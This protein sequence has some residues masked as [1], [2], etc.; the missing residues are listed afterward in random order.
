VDVV[1]SFSTTAG[2]PVSVSYTFTTEDI[3]SLNPAWATGLDSGVDRGFNVRVVQALDSS[4]RANSTVAAEGQLADPAVPA[5][6]TDVT[7]I[8]QMINFN[9][10]IDDGSGGNGLFRGGSPTA[11]YQ[12][13]DIDM[14]AEGLISSNTDD[15]DENHT[16]DWAMEVKT[17]VAYTEAGI[18]T[19]VVNSDDGFRV[20][21]GRTT[22]IEESTLELGVFDGGRGASND[23]AQSVFRY[24]VTQPGLYALRFI[25][26]EGGGGSSMEWSVD[27][28]DGAYSL[29]NDD[30][31]L[32]AYAS[33]T[34]DPDPVTDVEIT[35]ISVDGAGNVTVEFVGTLQTAP[36]VTGPYTDTGASSPFT[37]TPGGDTMFFRVVQ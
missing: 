6:L 27:N 33:R 31:G 13:A 10:D 30:S 34:G 24:V 29:L 22:D 12:I 23:A 17:Y 36:A 16:N 3:P 25:G 7:E 26:Y 8:F 21:A 2:D 28:G 1:V 37:T 20:T 14:A 32:F 9:Q 35:S 11:A 5:N 4:G 19:M 15:D 18:Y